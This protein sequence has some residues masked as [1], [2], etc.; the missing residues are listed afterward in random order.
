MYKNYSYCD[1]VESVKCWMCTFFY[2]EGRSTASY[3]AVVVSSG[4]Y[5]D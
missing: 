1:F 2:T 3:K 5:K 4:E